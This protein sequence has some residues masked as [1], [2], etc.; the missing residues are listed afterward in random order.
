MIYV[1][2]DW[3]DKNH[4]VFITDDTG[5]KLGS[6]SIENSPEGV[7]ELF[8][9]IRKVVKEQNQA[10]FALETSKGLLID[11]ILDAGYTVYPINPKAVDR[12]RDRYKVS[13]KK[14]D[15]FDALVLANIL[16]TDRNNYQPLLPDSPLTR[17]LRTLTN[18]YKFLLRLKTKLSN[19]ITSCLK[20]YYPVALSLFCK[21]GQQVSLNF[22]KKFDSPEAF[23]KLTKSKIK[24]FLSKNHYPGVEKKA[25]EVYHLS[26]EPQFNVEPSLA[27]AKSLYMLTLVKQLETLL[28][29]LETFE[30]EIEK[31]LNQHP[32]K[33]IFLSLP[34]SSTITSAKFISEF[35]DNR[36]RYKKISSVQ[37]EAGTCPVTKQS[38]NQRFVYFRRACR[39]SFRD[40]A[41]RFAFTSMKQSSWAKERYERYVG[42]GKKHPLALRCLAN[43]WLEIIFP[44]WKNRTLYSEQ[45]HLLKMVVKEQNL[46]L[47]K[48]GAL[49]SVYY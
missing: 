6:F 24:R 10:I 36:N 14:S 46:P 4:W 43:A 47:I 29:S 17:H 41:C 8:S 23:E 19:Q 18:E 40:A 28:V 21:L 22:L 11:S 26:Q 7:Q 32:D 16:R 34:G 5:S 1:G 27:S 3:A 31:L 12:Y 25:E 13:G 38:G 2:I 45:R 49:V 33:D 9:R 48:S 39:K 37:A 30:K 20:D 42:A 15:E 44:M 35:G